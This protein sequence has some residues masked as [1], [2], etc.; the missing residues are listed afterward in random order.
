MFKKKSLL[1]EVEVTIRISGPSVQIVSLNLFSKDEIRKF[2]KYV[3]EKKY[4]YL[5]FG[6]IRIGL[7][8]LFRHGINS[9]CIAEVFDTRH[10]VYDHAR[11]GTIVGNLSS[12]CQYGT[13]FPDYAISMSDPHLQECW[14]L[15]TG[16]QGLSLINDSEYLSIIIQTSFQLTNTVHPKLKQPVLKDCVTVG[17]TNAQVEGVVYSPEDILNEWYFQYKSLEDLKKPESKFKRIVISDGRVKLIPPR[18]QIERPIV[19]PKRHVYPVQHQEE[20]SSS[21]QPIT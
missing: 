9:P 18:P 17:M 4:S 15:M 8:P 21:R 10:Q 6:G 13:I 2:K 20:S 5:H 3:E 19:K 7:A 14:K 16:V 11:I 1:K 12:G